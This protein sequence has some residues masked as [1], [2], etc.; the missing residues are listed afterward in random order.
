MPRTGIV[1]Y[2]GER[3]GTTLFDDL[4]VAK[5]YYCGLPDSVYE[6]HETIVYPSISAQEILEEIDGK[7]CFSEL[8]EAEFFSDYFSEQD[9]KDLDE[10]LADWLKRG[11]VRCFERGDLVS[12]N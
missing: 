2:G 9:K 8:P 1:K 10:F 4:Q 5:D 6:W 7:Q 11:A 3:E 12:T